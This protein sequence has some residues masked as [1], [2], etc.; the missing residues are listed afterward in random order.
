MELVGVGGGR[1]EEEELAWR[2]EAIGRRVGRAW[3]CG[4]EL[5]VGGFGLH[6]CVSS[7]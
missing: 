5:G 6:V 2:G 7:A 1:A 3:V 4:G